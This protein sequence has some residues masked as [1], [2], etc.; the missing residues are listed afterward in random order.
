MPKKQTPKFNS[1]NLRATILTEGGEDIGLGHIYRCEAI[2]QALKRLNVNCEFIIHDD[3]SITDLALNTEYIVKNWLAGYKD[4][5]KEAGDIVIIDSYLASRDILEHI[6]SA[7]RLAVFIDDFNR[8]SY[9][10]GVVINSAI[11]AHLLEYEPLKGREFLLGVGYHPLRAE[12]WDC[13]PKDIN[14][15]VSNILVTMGGTDMR[16]L[17]PLILQLLKHRTEIKK[18]IVIGKGFGNI[19]Q[20][21]EI[22]DSTCELIRFPAAHK[23]KSLMTEADIAISAAGQT[24]YELACVGVPTITIGVAENQEINIRGWSQTGFIEF[25]GW[26]DDPLLYSN[27][28]TKL[29]LLMD[30]SLRI[31]KSEAGRSKI[32]GTGALQIGRKILNYFNN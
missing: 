22:A 9:P 20:I 24:L 1:R 12:F 15:I 13:N 7:F 2:T 27:I 30:Y 28:N 29:E 19:S 4:I 21:E 8:I 6:A 17:T 26:Y 3:S 14:Q 16:N 25:A 18:R 31:K 5:I 11:A 10:P 23:M 32:D